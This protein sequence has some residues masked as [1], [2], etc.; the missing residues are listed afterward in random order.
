GAAAGAGAG[1]LAG[2]GRGAR[3]SPPRA[4]ERTGTGAKSTGPRFLLRLLSHVEVQREFVRVRA[5]PDRVD[6]VLPLERDPGFDQVLGEHTAFQQEVVVG[7]E[8]VD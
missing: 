7:L 3:R 8:V 4:E 1:C 6:L 2:R 5:Q